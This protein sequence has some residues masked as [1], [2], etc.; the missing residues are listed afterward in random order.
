MVTEFGA[1]GL[2]GADVYDKM[3]ILRALRPEFPAAVF[4]TNNYDA[5]F[6][7]P[8]Q[9]GRHAQSGD[10]IAIRQHVAGNLSSATHRSISR[11][12]SDVH[13]RRHAGR[14]RANEQGGSQII[15]HGNRAFSKL[16]GT[17]RTI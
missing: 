17:A 10:R 4:F 1:I 6:E 12:Q 2:L 7:R 14:H 5:H 15:S 16:A 9:L 3:M 13:V 11:Q 8:R